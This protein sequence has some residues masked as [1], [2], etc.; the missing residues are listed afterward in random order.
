[1]AVYKPGSTPVTKRSLKHGGHAH[2]HQNHQYLH[3]RQPQVQ[4]IDEREIEKRSVGQLISATIDGQVVPWTNSYSGPGLA[5][6]SHPPAGA[7]SRETNVPASALSLHNIKP[8]KA[9]SSSSTAINTSPAI[10]KVSVSSAGQSPKPTSSTATGQGP[11]ADHGWT[12]QAYYNAVSGTAE[13]FTF[14]NHYGGTDGIPGTAAGGSALV[15]TSNISL[16]MVLLTENAAL[17]P[18]SHMPLPMVNPVQSHL[19]SSQTP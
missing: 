5:S 19:K 7:Q 4:E 6:S 17:E 18:P 15:L 10:S 16:I 8:F 13:G 14:L 9:T 11:V 1:M 12:R 2:R 3:H